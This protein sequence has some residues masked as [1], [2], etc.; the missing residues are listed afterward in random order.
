M[1]NPKKWNNRIS[2]RHNYLNYGLLSL[3]TRIKSLGY[4][5]LVVHGGF[6]SPDEIFSEMVILG[7]KKTTFPILV[8]ITSFF[9]FSW[10]KQFCSIL[11]KNI[12][13]A[14]VIV[15]GRWVTTNREEWVKYE[16]P[17]VDIVVSGLAEDL[18][19]KL[20]CNN[21]IDSNQSGIIKN[22]H[23][24]KVG[25]V[26][27][28][29]LDY[30]LLHNHLLFQPSIEVSRGCGRGCSFCGEKDFSLTKMKNP[31]TISQQFQHLIDIYSTHELSPYFEASFFKPNQ[32]WAKELI[33][34]RKNNG[35][36][37]QWRC[38]SR[39][40]I[41]DQKL[42]EFLVNGGLKVI[43]LGLESASHTQL[44]RM[45][46]TKTPNTYLE[47][48][49]LFIEFASSL[50]VWIKVNVLLFLGETLKT[51]SET[52]EWLDKHKNY[53][54]GVSVGSIIG[55]GL[56]TEVQHF[57]DS[58]NCPDASIAQLENKTIGVTRLNL[59]KEIDYFRSEELA[60]E[61]SREFM[62]KRAYY[63]LKSFSY[64]PRGYSYQQFCDDIP[65]HSDNI[66]FN[67]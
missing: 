33:N 29:N 11:K 42:T 66:P 4:E 23:S 54:K 41:F 59:S 6:Y 43:D 21:L 38:E 15:G 32:S 63:D 30:S 61:I 35:E 17:E 18:A 50:G 8:S 52:I 12:T 47:K 51:I 34:V 62:T 64:F 3:A 16:I 56:P 39:V 55:F 24:Y 67:N 5:A 49:S 36:V 19:E 14:K 22:P 60:I 44:L 46:K 13:N 9:A 65:K 48:A 28:I 7:L 40:D 2:R 45:N 53:I 25:S 10:A 27:E 31:S 58:F 57:M 37:Y 20:L 1:E 26:F